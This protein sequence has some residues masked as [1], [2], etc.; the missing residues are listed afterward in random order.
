V[1]ASITF[2]AVFTV[3]SPA[4]LNHPTG[5]DR[6][7]V[8]DD[9]RLVLVIDRQE[10]G[11]L[12]RNDYYER[13]QFACA[14][15]GRMAASLP[16]IQCLKKHSAGG[17]SALRRATGQSRPSQLQQ[18]AA[19]VKKVV[20]E[21]PMLFRKQSQMAVDVRAAPWAIRFVREP[22]SIDASASVFYA[23]GCKQVP[24]RGHVETCVFAGNGGRNPIRFVR[25]WVLSGRSYPD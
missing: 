8:W 2:F 16:K 17:F 25:W 7:G 15:D 23:C 19:A 18:S 21:T 4:S 10:V 9:H 11:R 22:E 24:D 6:A 1:A 13:K 3:K 5:A 14:S 20:L 12:P